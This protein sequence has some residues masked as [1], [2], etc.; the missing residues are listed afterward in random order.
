MR[1][2]CLEN[3]TVEVVCPLAGHPSAPGALRTSKYIV[4]FSY[5]VHLSSERTLA[6]LIISAEGLSVHE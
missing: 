3:A 5:A 1:P 4:V 2:S 6:P